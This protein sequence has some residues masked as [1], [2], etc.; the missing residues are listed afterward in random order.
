VA[1]LPVVLPT[2]FSL[3]VNLKTAQVLGIDIP[4]SILLRA[5][6]VIE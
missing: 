5:D 3:G 4:P 6:E 2:E 1:E